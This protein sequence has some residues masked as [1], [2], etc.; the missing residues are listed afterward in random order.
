MGLLE[1]RALPPQAAGPFRQH[2]SPLNITH[3]LT[4]SRTVSF[5]S[6]GFRPQDVLAHIYTFPIDI[7]LTEIAKQHNNP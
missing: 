6:M 5:S 2:P 7:K 3:D 4:Q 1:L